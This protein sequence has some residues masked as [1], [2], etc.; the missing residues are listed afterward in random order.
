MDEFVT[1]QKAREALGVSD[2]SLRNW[3]KEGKIETIKTKGGHRRYNIGKYLGKKVKKEGDR[4]KICYSRVS[5][6]GQRE[7]LERQEEYLREKFPEYI[8][9]KDIGSGINFKRRGLN[10]ILEWAVKGEVEEVVV[11]YK[12]R[13]C[14]FGYEIIEFIIQR[15]SNGKIVV[16]NE[17]NN[18]P[19]EELV[20]D[21]I[22]IVTVFSTRIY[23]LRRYKREFENLK[24]K[25]VPDK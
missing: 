11:T 17:A 22:S 7:D 2:E 6:P 21:L 15:C 18:S 24:D 20:N 19:Q 14:R 1:P 25:V 16:L 4:K 3:E 9:V 13:L 10:R 5:S 8:F 23:G 12:D